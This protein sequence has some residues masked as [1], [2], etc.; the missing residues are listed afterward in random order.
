MLLHWKDGGPVDI[1]SG[2]AIDTLQASWDLFRG[3]ICL[4]QAISSLVLESDFGT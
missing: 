2:L 1:S 4:Q 3:E